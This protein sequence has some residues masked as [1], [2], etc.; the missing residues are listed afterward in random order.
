MLFCLCDNLRLVL[1]YIFPRFFIF[2]RALT[3]TSSFMK[4]FRWAKLFFCSL[5]ICS[6][7][8]VLVLLIV[9]KSCSTKTKLKDHLLKSLITINIF[10]TFFKF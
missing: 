10:L 6:V 1:F 7:V 9:L 3:K 4:T 2:R 8:R 5:I